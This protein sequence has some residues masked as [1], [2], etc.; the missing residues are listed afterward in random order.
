MSILSEESINN[1]PESNLL[2][3]IKTDGQDGVRNYSILKNQNLQNYQKTNTNSIAYIVDAINKNLLELNLIQNQLNTLNNVN[4]EALLKKD[5][6]LRLE[7]DDLTKQLKDLESIQ[8]VIA[9]KSRYIDDSNHFIR[10]QEK[11]IQF[12]YVSIFFAIILFIVI[13][14]YSLGYIPFNF[15]TT[16]LFIITFL[17]ICYT[18]YYY[19]F[20]YVKT[21]TDNL[22]DK[23][24]PRM[25]DAVKKLNNY[26]EQEIE[27]DLGLF[28]KKDDWEKDNC[29]CEGPVPNEIIYP[30]DTE[31]S[32]SKEVAGNF[33]Y[34]GSAP[35][36]LLPSDKQLDP[37]DRINWADYSGDGNPK[38][39][40]FGNMTL[41][42]N[43]NFYNTKNL[44]N[45]PELQK[46]KYN[47]NLLVNNITLTS[48]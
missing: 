19:N 2:N 14:L 17:Y 4:Q 16:L 44:K 29:E 11:D 37:R 13:L 3:L 30:K 7:N 35:Q 15:F 1:S 48:N 38:Y 32:G 47:P 5:Q 42:D 9:N 25:Y 12:L 24:G 43:N 36:Q 40:P 39:F 22:L 18:I 33:Y 20:M 28:N 6:L 27:F 46:N 45:D 34:D 41:Y 10:K 21:S 31:Y 23:S 8:S 26:I